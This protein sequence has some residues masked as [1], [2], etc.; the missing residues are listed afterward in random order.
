[1]KPI[2]FA[3]AMAIVAF[4]AAAATYRTAGLEVSNPWSRPAAAGTTGAG[5]MSLANL[6][7]RPDALVRVESPVAERVE[8]H[9][10]SMAGGVMRM[11]KLERTPLGPG[12]RQAFA[13]GG[14]HLMFIRLK[15]PLAAGDKLPATLVFQSGARLTVEFV[16][17]T[18]LGAPAAHAG[19]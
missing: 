13:P 3:V 6:K 17:G 10:S 16:V 2:S 7:T 4:P 15:R 8:M 14:H 12:A 18:G 9:S 5:Y 19:H 11:A 1:M